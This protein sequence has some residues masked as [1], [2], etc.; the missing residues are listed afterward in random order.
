MM[1]VDC[2]ESTGIFLI[3][4]IFMIDVR[5]LLYRFEI[6]PHMTHPCSIKSAM[7]LHEYLHRYSFIFM[8]LSEYDCLFIFLGS[9]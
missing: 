1:R 2:I 6:H 7:N 5:F 8:A 9:I 3:I 4:L